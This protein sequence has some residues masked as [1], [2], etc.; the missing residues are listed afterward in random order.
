MTATRGEILANDSDGTYERLAVVSLRH[1]LS[2]VA[3]ALVG[4]GLGDCP[5]NGVNGPHG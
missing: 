1:S 3:L 5:I 4:L 2:T